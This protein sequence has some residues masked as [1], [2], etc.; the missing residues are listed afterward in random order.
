MSS[1]CS[2]CLLGLRDGVS[3]T[4]E[5]P[6][7]DGKWP[8]LCSSLSRLRSSEHSTAKAGLLKAKWT[9]GVHPYMVVGKG[10]KDEAT[11]EDSM[12]KPLGE[13][14][15][16]DA[17]SGQNPRWGLSDGGSYAYF[18]NAHHFTFLSLDGFISRRLRAMLRRQKH[19]PGQGQ[20]RRD[21]KQWPNAFFA[22]LGLFTMSEAHRLARQSR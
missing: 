4:K 5:M 17:S 2:L 11:S 12:P 18:Q 3:P 14:E 6:P 15:R 8:R 19:R 21:H 20:C 9:N 16:I 7:L 10:D 13:G 22:D 1:S